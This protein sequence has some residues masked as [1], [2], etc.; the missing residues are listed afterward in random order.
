MRAVAVAVGGLAVAGEVDVSGH[1]EVRVA[2]DARIDHVGVHVRNGSRAVPRLGRTRVGVY[3]V[4]A[5]GKRLCRGVVGLVGLHALHTFVGTHRAEAPVGDDG[6]E[7]IER[8]AVDE[9]YPQ[10]VATSHPFGRPTGVG[11][12][13]LQHYHVAIGRVHSFGGLDM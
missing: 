3:L 12:A 4:D 8:M 1:V 13:P 9:A 11:C 6:G 2:I 7:A 5:P 10:A